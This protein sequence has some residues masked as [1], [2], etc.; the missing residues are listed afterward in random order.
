MVECKA[1]YKCNSSV[2]AYAIQIDCSFKHSIIREGEGITTCMI[3]LPCDWGAVGMKEKRVKFF[4]PEIR[5]QIGMYKGIVMVNSLKMCWAMRCVCIKEASS[6]MEVSI[7]RCSVWSA[8]AAGY[9]RG[10]VVI[11]VVYTVYGRGIII[12]RISCRQAD[13]YVPRQ[14]C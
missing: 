9:T 6:V 1:A 8:R 3:L 7:R 11:S 13:F 14:E 12:V 2:Q 5:L 10:N 4:F